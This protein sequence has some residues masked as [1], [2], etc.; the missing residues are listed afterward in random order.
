LVSNNMGLYGY[1]PLPARGA[2]MKELHT[3]IE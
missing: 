3:S 1:F 2:S